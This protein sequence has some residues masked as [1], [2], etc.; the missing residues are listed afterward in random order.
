VKETSTDSNGYW[1]CRLPSGR[2]GVEYTHKNFKPV[3]RNISIPD[4]VD[5]FEVR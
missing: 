2:F 4:G 3:N 1:E 5:T